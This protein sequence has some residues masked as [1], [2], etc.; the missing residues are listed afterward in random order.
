MYKRSGDTKYFVHYM[1]RANVSAVAEVWAI[2]EKD[3]LNK[4][5]SNYGKKE[6]LS[7]GK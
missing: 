2:D 4:F 3:A 7:I 6:I 1:V 5:E